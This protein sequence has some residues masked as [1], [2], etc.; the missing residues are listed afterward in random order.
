MNY[1]H[2]MTFIAFVWPSIGGW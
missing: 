1:L 2:F